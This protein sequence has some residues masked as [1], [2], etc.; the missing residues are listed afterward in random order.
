L[1]SGLLRALD[2]SCLDELNREEYEEAQQNRK[3]DD[4]DD[5]DVLLQASGR[6]FRPRDSSMPDVSAKRK[7]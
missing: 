1:Y 7:L 3:S 4:E 6:L 5:H 2:A